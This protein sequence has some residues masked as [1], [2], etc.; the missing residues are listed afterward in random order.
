MRQTKILR[1]YSHKKKKNKKILLS[2]FHCALLERDWGADAYPFSPHC[3]PSCVH[4]VL[5]SVVMPSM[6]EGG[7]R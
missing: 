3:L 4:Y 5:A 7:K 6:S 2:A 1:I